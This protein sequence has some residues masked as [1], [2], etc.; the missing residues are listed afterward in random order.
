MAAQQ[1]IDVIAIHACSIAFAEQTKQSDRENV[2]VSSQ[3][4]QL[5]RIANL[6]PLSMFAIPLP[7]YEFGRIVGIIF[8][9]PGRVVLS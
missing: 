5:L 8:D 7:L 6:P 2:L 1:L 4:T 3:F 9:L